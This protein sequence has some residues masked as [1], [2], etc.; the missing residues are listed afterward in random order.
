MPTGTWLPA[1]NDIFAYAREL[2]GE[3]RVVLLNFADTA[4]RVPIAK[5]GITPDGLRIDVSTEP[6]GGH[7]R[8][9][10]TI[11]LAPDEGV[12]LDLD[13]S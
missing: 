4:V 9:G 2:D 7:E 6:P 11:E 5:L 13:G 3:R 1:P 10:K 8:I 12:L